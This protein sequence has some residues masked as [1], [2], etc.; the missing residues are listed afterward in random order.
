MLSLNYQ[1]TS[2][3]SGFYYFIFSVSSKN[4]NMAKNVGHFAVVFLWAKISK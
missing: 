3:K 1:N 4:R 2:K